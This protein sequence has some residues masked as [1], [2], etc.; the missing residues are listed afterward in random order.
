VNIV[1]ALARACTA[2]GLAAA[3]TSTT[4]LNQLRFRGWVMPK[5]ETPGTWVA[6]NAGRLAH[7]RGQALEKGGRT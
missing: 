6:T 4:V 7:R 1:D 5:H 3:D 2:E